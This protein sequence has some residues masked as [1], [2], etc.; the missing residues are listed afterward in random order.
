MA[1]DDST[2][3]A[4]VAQVIPVLFLAVMV[5]LR[6]QERHNESDTSL[7][8]FVLAYVSATVIGEWI[9]LAAL[10]DHHKLAPIEETVVTMAF[11]LGLMLLVVRPIRLR[12]D[13]LAERHSFVPLVVNVLFVVVV[14]LM[15][16]EVFG[17]VR[18]EAIAI[19]LS[20]LIVIVF[21]VA[22]FMAVGLRW[23]ELPKTKEENDDDS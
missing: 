9:V 5:Q 19:T 7:D 4:T 23:R 3:L 21:A 10:K 20:A 13:A 22:S 2:Y 6:L 15:L 1:K 14:I 11:L 17:V 12:Y 16:L 18:T 8:L